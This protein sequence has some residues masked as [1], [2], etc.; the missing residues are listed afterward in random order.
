M[1][2]TSETGHAKNVANFQTLTSV[3]NGYGPAYNPSRAEL[4][5]PAL[6]VLHTNAQNSLAAVNTAKAGLINVINTRQTAFEPLKKLATRI[7]NALDAA[8]GSDKLVD[9]AKT[10]NRKIQGVRKSKTNP[11]K[12]NTISVSQQSYNSL[13]EN[14][15]RLIELLSAEPAYAP[16]ETE[17][18]VTELQNTLNQLRDANNQVNNAN[19]EYNNALI[20]RNATLYEPGNG[21]TNIALDVKKYVKSVYGTSAPEYKQI[22]K[23]EFTKPRK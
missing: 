7:I 20:A 16:N 5:L 13:A 21:L 14:F 11:E 23:L 17:L 1:V 10:I 6:S 19:V 2:S 3:C 8:G 12:S 22:S 18:Q 15:A 4:Q 9:D